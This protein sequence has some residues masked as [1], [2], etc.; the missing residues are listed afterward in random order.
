MKP[1]SVLGTG[2]V[3]P[4]GASWPATRTRLA[5]GETASS[6]TLEF[7]G[8]AHTVFRTPVPEPPANIA[9]RVR[10]SSA[11]SHFACAAASEA[12]QAAGCPDASST[13]LVL[14]ASDGA[15]IYTRRFYED[16]MNSRPASPLLFPETVYNA[17]ASHIAAL[18]DLDGEVVTC[19]GDATAA[20]MA[21]ATAG[22]IL[23]SGSAAT[24]LVVAAEELDGVT[25]EAYRQWGLSG[26]DAAILSEGAVALVLGRSPAAAQIDAL[27]CRGERP[28]RSALARCIADVEGP[29]DSL[30]RSRSGS[31]I[32]R[33]EDATLHS[34]PGLPTH[35]PKCQTG[36]AFAVSALLQVA[37]AADS[38]K[39]TSL[40]TLAGWNGQ[41]AAVR[42]TRS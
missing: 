26:P 33:C 22:E 4:L 41:A 7:G 39:G 40:V 29:F 32:D 36:E 2:C 30:V 10:R 35:D 42:V 8:R 38:C 28:L 11:I 20:A 9:A 25:C 5:S 1:L 6:T 14:A 31:R 18:L 37:L 19:V 27:A 24:C 23:D 13:A 12:W 21:L 15:V 34:C 3:S 17:P 16:V